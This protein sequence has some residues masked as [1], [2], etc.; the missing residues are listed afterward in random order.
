LYDHRINRTHLQIANTALRE[1]CAHASLEVS[2]HSYTAF[3]ELFNDAH[4]EHA[5]HNIADVSAL[6]LVE[7][8]VSQA[9]AICAHT[10]TQL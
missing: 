8:Y 2:G 9:L 5:L 1:Y 3:I 7:L 10:R 6:F 4:F